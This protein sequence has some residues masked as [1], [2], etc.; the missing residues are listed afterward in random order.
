MMVTL[1]RRQQS[2][3]R[4]QRTGISPGLAQVMLGNAA[5][6]RQS[7]RPEPRR[8]LGLL[9]LVVWRAF[10]RRFRRRITPVEVETF[11]ADRGI[12]VTRLASG[13][14]MNDHAAVAVT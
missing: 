4:R 5:G 13:P 1:E 6:D 9:A 8:F 7:L 12:D 2:Q 3:R 10:G 11:C 14:T